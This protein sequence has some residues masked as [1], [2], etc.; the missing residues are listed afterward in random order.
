MIIILRYLF[1]IF[2]PT[3]T[4]AIVN[5]NKVKYESFI[6]PKINYNDLI[7]SG[8]Q[9]PNYIA[10]MFQTY[11][12]I[13]IINI[14][15]FKEA[16]ENALKPLSNCLL[17]D[18]DRYVKTMKDGSRRLSSAAI[19]KN[20]IIGKLSNACSETV[21]SNLRFTIDIVT[22]N[23]FKALDLASVKNNNNI[24]NNKNNYL[25]FPYKSF[26][27]LM[28]NGIQLE[29]L[30]SF[31]PSKNSSYKA[32]DSTLTLD[33]HVDA[34]IMI[35]M[36]NGYYSSS[37]NQRKDLLLELP[38][39]EVV[40]A[41][42]D[43]DALVL[44]M[45]SAASQWLSPILGK[46]IR[47]MPHS[48]EMDKE[49]GSIRSWYGK[50]FLPPGDAMLPNSDLTY[51]KFRQMELQ[52]Q[53]VA[54]KPSKEFLSLACG[55]RDDQQLLSLSAHPESGGADSCQSDEIW[56]WA[57]CMPVDTLPCGSNAVCIDT[58]TNQQ[59]DPNKHCSSTCKPG[60]VAVPPPQNSSSSDAYCLTPGVSMYMD[61]FTAMAGQP[62]GSVQCVNLLFV[63]WTLDNALK[64]G[65][66][67]VGVFF[68]GVMIQALTYVRLSLVKKKYGQTCTSLLTL[69]L[70]SIQMVLSYMIMLVAMTYNVEL[71]CMVCTGLMVGYALFHLKM[72]QP[73][74]T[75]QCCPPEDDDDVVYTT[76]STHA[77][78]K[79]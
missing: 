30:H 7:S 6:V 32:V 54:T 60:C 79:Y 15:N 38:S 64:F 3:I 50:M 33:M 40:Y 20:G 67:C 51:S 36:T 72:P 24:N 8:F 10:N 21:S 12:A 37:E 53:S 42:T 45:G 4:I 5:N 58:T 49:S 31:F 77:Q 55:G 74:N 41:E 17:N 39:G 63:T 71:F 69:L 73:T 66:A 18:D 2:I 22:Q 61:G 16:R 78:D 52:Y 9:T 19:S 1:L 27:S 28:T 62:K 46:P 59:T 26:S 47:A 43:S 65:F 13:Q 75:D 56:C 76:L 35:A 25:M 48:L 57:T 70:Y 23:V 29:H 68:T 11:G 34:G 44:M 14:P